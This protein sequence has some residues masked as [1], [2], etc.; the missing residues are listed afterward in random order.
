MEKK[1]LEIYHKE[2][3]ENSLSYSEIRKKYNIPRGTWNYWIGYKNKLSADTRKYRCNDQYF[4]NIDSGLKSYILG[5]LYA[6][7]YI[8]NDFRIGLLISEQDREVA[9]LILNE[10][11]PD[12]NLKNCNYQNI[13]RK[14]QVK[15]RITSRRLYNR[16]RSIGFH[17]EKTAKDSDVFQHIPSDYKLDF[18]RGYTDGDGS[19][20]CDHVIHNSYKYGIT[21]SNGSKQIL[22]DISDYFKEFD[23]HLTL[24][25]YKN[26]N[27]YYNLHTYKKRDSYKICRLLYHNNEFALTRK[28][29]TANRVIELCTN[30]ELTKSNKRLLVV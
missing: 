4:D 12:K 30:T 3:I 14:P 27:V 24:K 18:I 11:C 1:L 20:R 21:W 26:K 8:S 2:H 6:D 23:I 19:I 7:G 9:E 25:E 13:K 15:F 28:K 22:E 17:V 5:F 16:L 10:L 29:I